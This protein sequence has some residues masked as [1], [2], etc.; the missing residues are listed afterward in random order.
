[1]GGGG[2]WRRTSHG[3]L[4]QSGVVLSDRATS[5]QR[6]HRGSLECQV[7]RSE[8]SGGPTDNPALSLTSVPTLCRDPLPRS[9]AC[10]VSSAITHYDTTLDGLTH[11]GTRPSQSPFAMLDDEVLSRPTPP[12]ADILCD[13]RLVVS[14]LFM[15]KNVVKACNCN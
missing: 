2:L 8:A 11:P 5:D 14:F 15:F 4:Q 7:S 9:P 13:T 12:L 1:M 3:S 6:S 10:L